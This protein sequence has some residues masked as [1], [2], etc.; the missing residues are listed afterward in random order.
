MAEV[1]HEWNECDIMLNKD[2]KIIS[3]E[4][5]KSGIARGIDLN[6]CL[7]LET[8]N[9]VEKITAGDVSLRTQQ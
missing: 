4:D 7:L 1:V 9:G 6:G 8:V 5:K 3:N 2:V